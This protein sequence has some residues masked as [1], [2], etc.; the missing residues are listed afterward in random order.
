M[1]ILTAHTIDHSSVV[2]FYVDQVRGSVSSTP[3]I[4]QLQ[5]W[6][7]TPSPHPGLSDP[8]KRT[9]DREI[10]ATEG[11]ILRR[12]YQAFV[13]DT[14]TLEEFEAFVAHVLAVFDE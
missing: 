1:A 10:N 2:S 6:H 14:L 9:P 4:I 13:D 12:L 3:P 7:F 11:G 5:L 8:T